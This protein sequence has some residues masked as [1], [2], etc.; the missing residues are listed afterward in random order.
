MIRCCLCRHHAGQPGY[1]LERTDL[2]GSGWRCV[3][4]EACTQRVKSIV[5]AHRAWSQV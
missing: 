2:P 5:S 3:D 4:R 1:Y